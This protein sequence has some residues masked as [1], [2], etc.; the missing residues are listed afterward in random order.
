MK[1][2]SRGTQAWGWHQGFWGRPRAG[3]ETWTWNPAGL[4]GEGADGLAGGLAILSIRTAPG[5]AGGRDLGRGGLISSWFFAT[6]NL[7]LKANGNQK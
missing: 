7:M 5:L 2:N 6:S 4:A 1:L 3:R